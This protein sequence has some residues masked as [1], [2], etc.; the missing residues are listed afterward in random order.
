MPLLEADHVSQTGPF[1]T[2]LQR[3]LK[4][5]KNQPS[6][7]YTKTKPAYITTEHFCSL[8]A[9]VAGIKCHLIVTQVPKIFILIYNWRKRVTTKTTVYYEFEIKANVVNEGVIFL[10][11]I[12]FLVA[13]SS[14]NSLYKAHFI[15]PPPPAPLNQWSPIPILTVTCRCAVWQVLGVFQSNVVW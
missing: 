5:Y 13:Q 2:S 14:L 12:L 9:S 1:C 10:G 3:S 11:K 4:C 8:E 7:I 15:T 6:N